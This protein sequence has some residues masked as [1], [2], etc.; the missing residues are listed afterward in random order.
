MGNRPYRA[1]RRAASAQ[2]TRRT[3]LD[4]ALTLFE[5]NGYQGTTL[6]EI[7][8]HAG[9]SLNAI[10]SGIGGK[11]HLLTALIT[12]VAEDATSQWHLSELDQAATG[13]QAL[14]AVASRIRNVL[15]RNEWMIG[16]LYDNASAD[17][18]IAEALAGGEADYRHRLGA[19]VDRLDELGALK[20]TVSLQQARDIIW[21]YFGFPPWRELRAAGWD[22]PQAEH[23]LVE[24]AMH[25]LVKDSLP[26][27]E[28]DEP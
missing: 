11:P 10:Y 25:A 28:I 20:K 26:R 6:T 3:I 13:R 1:T 2:A 23:W 5:E 14:K 12:E 15:E 24:Q 22:W 17:K 4:A 21:F 9:V 19:L 7:A 8:A 18:L 27:H 16:Q